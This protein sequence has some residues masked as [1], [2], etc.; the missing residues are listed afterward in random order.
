MIHSIAATFA[1]EPSE[2]A[3]EGCPI[4]AVLLTNCICEQLLTFNCIP[5]TATGEWR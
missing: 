2:G 4:H 5:T 3:L 1:Y